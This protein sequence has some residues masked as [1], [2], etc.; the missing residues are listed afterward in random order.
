MNSWLNFEPDVTQ[1]IRVTLITWPASY[2]SRTPTVSPISPTDPQHHLHHVRLLGHLHWHTA[3]LRPHFPF[4]LFLIP[5]LLPVRSILSSPSRLWR[6]CTN[7]LLYRPPH[8][9]RPLHR[10][11]RLQLPRPCLPRPV[12][13]APTRR[14]KPKPFL[15]Q[16]R[17]HCTLLPPRQ[18]F[19]T[20]VT[21]VVRRPLLWHWHYLPRRTS[22]R[23]CLGP[24]R[25]AP[26]VP[27][28]RTTAAEIKCGAERDDSAR[29]VPGQ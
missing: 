2:I 1:W 23:R 4:L 11:R 13:S 22:Y 17:R 6:L 10:R 12:H 16:P 18:P 14:A 3:H 20:S 19:R 29:A 28:E 7:N 15:P 24:R 9:L 26:Q 21:W 27:S 5:F 8:C 25:G